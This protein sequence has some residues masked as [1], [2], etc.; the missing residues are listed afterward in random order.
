[1]ETIY[2]VLA[3]IA[4]VFTVRLILKLLFTYVIKIHSII[5]KFLLN[6]R[7]KVLKHQK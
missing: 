2:I 7:K 6:K 4:G 3:G 5:W 1:M